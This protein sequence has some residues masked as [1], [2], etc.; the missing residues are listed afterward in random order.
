MK[1]KILLGGVAAAA[2]AVALGSSPTPAHAQ[3]VTLQ[4]IFS[5]PV[6]LIINAPSREMIKEVNNVCKGKIKIEIKGGPEAIPTNQQMSA[7]KRGVVDFYA[8]AAGYYQGQVPELEALYGS[9]KTSAEQRRDGGAAMLDKFFQ[10]RVNARYFAEYGSGYKFLLMTKEKPKLTADGGVDL[11]GV[12]MRGTASYKAL[13]EALGI[14]MVSIFQPEI[15][16]ALE[17]GMIQGVGWVNNS[18]VDS[19]WTKFVKYRIHPYFMQGGNIIVMNLDK[20]KSLNAEQQ[21]CLEDTIVKN[22]AVAQ[23]FFEEEAGREAARMKAEGVET[24]TLTGEGSKKFLQAFQ[25][26]HWKNMEKLGLSPD[27]VRA[28][29]KVFFDSARAP[30]VFSGS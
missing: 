7:I 12:S 27:Q 28:L 2:F 11:K 15:F 1:T 18:I 6:E 23:K 25:D 20:W 26:G 30:G 4:T 13:Y 16:S 19:G 3:E 5:I 24:V 21:K 14:N 29:H 8:G 9:N 17:R 22:E 10:E